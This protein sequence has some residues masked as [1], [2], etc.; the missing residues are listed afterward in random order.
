MDTS[1]STALHI[2]VL[3]D[4]PG[5][6]GLRAEAIAR[7][8]GTHPVR[9]RQMLARLGAAG[10][11]VTLRGRHGGSFLAR[12]LHS[13]SLGD[14]YIAVVPETAVLFPVHATS[15]RRCPVGGNIELALLAPLAEVDAV[16]LETLRGIR[17]SRVAE[18]VRRLARRRPT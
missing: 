17:V 13:V 16:V 3:L 14:V 5:G 9:V 7:S 11:T 10:L 8:V 12:P 2:L 15:N 1:F 18:S 4:A 6:R